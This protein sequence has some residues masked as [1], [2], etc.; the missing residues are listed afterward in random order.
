MLSVPADGDLLD[1]ANWTCS[2]FLPSN[3]A[4][5]GGDMGAWLEGNAVVTPSGELV[6]VLRGQTKS[7]DEKAGGGRRPSGKKGSWISGMQPY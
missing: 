1:A 5:N 4:W 7:A 3:R 2:D 6:D